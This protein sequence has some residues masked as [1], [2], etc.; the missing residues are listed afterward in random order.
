MMVLVVDGR[1]YIIH[2]A[3][4]VNWVSFLWVSLLLAEFP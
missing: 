1:L 2:M 4:S 3:V